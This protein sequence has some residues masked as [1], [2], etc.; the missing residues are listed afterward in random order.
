FPEVIDKSTKEAEK[1]LD[2]EGI[3]ATIIGDGKKIVAA[4]MEEDA[5]FL[6]HQRVILYTDQP[7]VPDVKGWTQRDIVSLGSQLGM[8]VEIEGS[9]F[10][11]K[12]SIKPGKKI[13]DDMTLKVELQPT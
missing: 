11:V 8:E 1:I 6:K 9:G 7:K 13:K 10:A 3:S 4:N 2:K 5:E 12:Q